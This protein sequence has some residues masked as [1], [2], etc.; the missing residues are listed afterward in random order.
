MNMSE[1]DPWHLRALLYY[2]HELSAEVVDTAERG[3]AILLAINETIHQKKPIEI[4]EE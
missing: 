1:Y 3:N 2:I 4:E